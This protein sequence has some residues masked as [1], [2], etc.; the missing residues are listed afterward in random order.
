[1]EGPSLYLAQ[2]HLQPFKGKKVNA[3]SGNT[4]TVDAQIF[5]YKEIKDIYSWGKHLVFQF[6][7][8]ALRVHFLMFG[9]FEAN[10]NGVSVTG[11]YKRTKEPRLSF[12][13]DNGDIKMFNCSLK[14]HE[15]DNLKA[16]YDFSIDVMSKEWDSKKALKQVL[17]YPEEEISDVLLDQT[18][19]SGVGNIIRNEALFI[20]RTLPTRKVKEIPKARLKAIVEEAHDYSWKF[21]EWRKVF[22]LKKHFQIYRKSTCP[23]CG[24]KVTRTQTGKRKRMSSFC[25]HCQK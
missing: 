1:M 16:S 21:Y 6:D 18:I 23:I 19:F 24:G 2:Q 17:E 8:V 22:Q 15:T 5:L 12:E 14:V 3:V 13:F 11:D 7:T 9:S 25:E 10:V 4:K 20:E